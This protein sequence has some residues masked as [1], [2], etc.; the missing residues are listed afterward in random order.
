MIQG[1]NIPPIILRR[2]K[3]IMKPNFLS[4][5]LLAAASTNALYAASLSGIVKDA[6]SHEELI[7]AHIYVKENPQ[8]G[9]TTGLDGSFVLNNIPEHQPVTLVCAYVGYENREQI[10]KEPAPENCLSMFSLR[11]TSWEKLRFWLRPT[12][13][14]MQVHALVRSNRLSLA[15]L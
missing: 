8:I 9:T 3:I 7:G 2:E 10:I 12:V 11:T 4:L 15:I 1:C 6:H 13:V 5:F 14:P